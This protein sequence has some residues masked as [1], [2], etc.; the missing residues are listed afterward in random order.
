MLIETWKKID[1]AKS[2]PPLLLLSLALLVLHPPA[3]TFL[4]T[5]PI[6]GPCQMPDGRCPTQETDSW[7]GDA[8]NSLLIAC[9]VSHVLLLS[10]ICLILQP[11]SKLSYMH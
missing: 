6:C 9:L 7:R 4:V 8:V 3:D 10:E 1:S 11:L 2:H 5:L